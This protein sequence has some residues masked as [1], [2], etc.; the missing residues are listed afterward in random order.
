MEVA[1]NEALIPCVI[2]S[3]TTLL[4]ILVNGVGNLAVLVA[5]SVASIVTSLHVM[6]GKV[7]L[8]LVSSGAAQN[9]TLG[10]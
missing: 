9:D 6:L 2:T 3:I 7:M 1:V 8:I 10:V 5:L 4:V